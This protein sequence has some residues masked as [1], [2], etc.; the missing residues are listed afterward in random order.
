MRPVNPMM[1]GVNTGRHRQE[2]KSPKQEEVHPAR[3]WFSDYPGLPE[4]INQ[5]GNYTI[6][7]AVVSMDFSLG[8]HPN[9]NPFPQTDQ[10]K[11]DRY[12]HEY[13]YQPFVGNVGPDLAHWNF[14]KTPDGVRSKNHLSNSLLNPLRKGILD[15]RRAYPVIPSIPRD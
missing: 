5:E 15:M 3:Q 10:D 2:R 1:G 12:K 13:I 14:V 11:A 9:L 4:T 7:Y 6:P 8:Q